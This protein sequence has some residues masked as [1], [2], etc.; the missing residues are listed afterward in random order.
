MRWAVSRPRSA[1]IKISSSSSSAA[2]SSLRL[3]KRSVMPPVSDCEVRARPPL[4]RCHQLSRRFLVS[5]PLIA[6]GRPLRFSRA[7]DSP[8]RMSEE[9]LRD[10]LARRVLYRDALMLVIDKPA[11]VP[12]HR[13]PASAAWKN[14]PSLEDAFDVLCF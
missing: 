6:I 7:L 13:G 14:N 3:V 2:A 8:N 11:G 12:V 9:E 4:R 5:V 1:L 10:E